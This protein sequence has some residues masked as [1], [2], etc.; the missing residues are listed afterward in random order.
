MDINGYTVQYLTDLKTTAYKFEFLLGT[1]N[2]LD[3]MFVLY[4][5]VLATSTNMY[6]YSRYTYSIPFHPQ[7]PSNDPALYT[8]KNKNLNM[9]IC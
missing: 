9:R 6:S 1:Q 8:V 4:R 7:H 5:A 2:Q 3:D